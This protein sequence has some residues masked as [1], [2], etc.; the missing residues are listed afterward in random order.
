MDERRNLLEST[1]NEARA[2]LEQR[3]A[4]FEPASEPPRN[5]AEQSLDGAILHSR[6]QAEFERDLAPLTERAKKAHTELQELQVER[7]VVLETIGQ[8]EQVTRW[9]CERNARRTKRKVSAYWQA[10]LAV[11]HATNPRERLP[12]QPPPLSTL[13]LPLES[14][15]SWPQPLREQEPSWD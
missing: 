5:R 13:R 8:E 11:Y 10:A 2:S 15:G 9:N 3:R 12:L 14:V 4:G 7:A 6:R 1:H